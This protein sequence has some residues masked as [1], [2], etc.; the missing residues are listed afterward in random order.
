MV[1]N[2]LHLRN[3]EISKAQHIRSG[4]RIGAGFDQVTCFI[5]RGRLRHEAVERDPHRRLI[6]MRD[7]EAEATVEGDHARE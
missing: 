3:R 1:G 2:F 4:H 5:E 7:Q 6:V